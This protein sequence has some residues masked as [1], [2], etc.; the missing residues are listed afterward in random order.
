M[1][2]NRQRNRGYALMTKPRQ[3]DSNRKMTLVYDDHD[4]GSLATIAQ[5]ADLTAKKIGRQ[6]IRAAVT[7]EVADY[8]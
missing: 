4:D 3:I 2:D 6:H 5:N 8:K 1:R 7:I